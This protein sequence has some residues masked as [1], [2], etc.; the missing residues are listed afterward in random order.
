MIQND[1]DNISVRY[2]IILYISLTSIASPNSCSFSGL[3][4]FLYFIR[5]NHHTSS[6]NLFIG[7]SFLFSNI[8]V[9]DIRIIVVHCQTYFLENHVKPVM[10]KNA[11]AYLMAFYEICY[12]LFN[13]MPLDIDIIAC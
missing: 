5:F 2:Q 3:Q 1:N 9:F 11:A 6:A 10:S 4:Y 8:V 12:R 7:L 13:R